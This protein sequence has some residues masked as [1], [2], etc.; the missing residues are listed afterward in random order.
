MSFGGSQSSSESESRV[1]DWQ[2]GFFEDLYRRAAGVAGDQ[3]NI[4]GD[5]R[6]LMERFLPGAEAGAAGFGDILSGASPGQE[7]LNTSLGA[8]NPYLG[9]QIDALGGDINRNLTQ[10]ILPTVRSG[11]VSVGSPGGSRA[12]IAE[13][14]A[15]RGAQEEFA[16]GST[17]LRFGD[18]LRQTQAAGTATRNEL[19]ASAGA[20]N[21]GS[22]LY[23]LG[24]TPYQ[25]SWFPLQQY[26]AALGRPILEGESE[27]DS[28]GLSFGF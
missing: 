11:G 2:R 25:A 19:A 15:L 14:L 7:F 20:V 9:A 18:L 16:E 6:A 22:Q 28:L 27:S 24:F 4:G 13:G 1:P 3:A 23:N 26:A 8:E 21:A 17:R 5:A 12:A 10:N